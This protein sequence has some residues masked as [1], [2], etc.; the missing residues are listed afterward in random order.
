[1][2]V[3][4]VISQPALMRN[5]GSVV[6]TLASRGHEVLLTF[7]RRQDEAGW[8]AAQELAERDPR[9][10]V[11]LA[12]EIPERILAPGGLARATVDYL[13]SLSPAF[14]GTA[15]RE[16]LGEL[17]RHAAARR[18]PPSLA[19][20]PRSRTAMLAAARAVERVLPCVPRLVSFVEEARPDVVLVTPLI[21]LWSKQPE[22]LRA[23]TRLGIPTGYLMASWDNLTKGGL[24]HGD[25][26]LVAIWNHD[27]VSEAIDLHDVPR[28]RITVTGAY[29]FEHWFGREPSRSH[30]AFLG[31]IG[32]PPDKPMLLYLCTSSLA[33]AEEEFVKRWI[34]ETRERSPALRE[35]SVLVRPYPTNVRDWASVDLGERV[36]VWPL[37]GA[38]PVGPQAQ[39]DYFDSLSH[40]AGAVGLSTTAQLECALVGLPVHTILLPEF[41]DIQERFPHFRRFLAENGGPVVAATGWDEHTRDLE[42]GL[43]PD[44]ARDAR[45]AA[46][47]DRF[48][49]A[50][51]TRSPAGRLAEAVESLVTGL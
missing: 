21:G 38:N 6:E 34:H 35:T 40:A 23:A 13:V 50:G 51:C 7:E 30:E 45:L 44:P 41:R 36:V 33:G 5:F 26:D 17:H 37:E 4:L 15:I 9:I 1:M 3:L 46:F 27:L 12:P 25:P 22:I 49:M 29:A 43:V 18:L 39:A 11:G 8:S 14:A 31:Q 32:L 16:R 20:R 10:S 47:V 28:D 24:L 2:R 48:V 19:H 42:A